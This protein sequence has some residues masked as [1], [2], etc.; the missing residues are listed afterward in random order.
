MDPACR[1]GS[2]SVRTSITENYLQILLSF[3]LVYL[4]YAH[5]SSFSLLCFPLR[6]SMKWCSY[7]ICASN[8]FLIVTFNTH[9]IST[10]RLETCKWDLSGN[11]WVLGEGMSSRVW[12]GILQEPSVMPIL[13]HNLY[14]L[15]LFLNMTSFVSVSP[16]HLCHLLRLMTSGPWLALSNC[17][18]H[19]AGTKIGSMSV[20]SNNLQYC[21]AKPSLPE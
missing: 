3:I 21:F 17:L 9:F 12:H 8:L 6:K 19:I 14:G 1:N 2:S 18:F 15:C 5:R 10:I 7:G 13:M 20:A 16:C 11:Q 4:F